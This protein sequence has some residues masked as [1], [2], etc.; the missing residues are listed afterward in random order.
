MR[1]LTSLPCNHI[2]RPD[3]WGTG[4]CIVTLLL[5]VILL[6]CLP[7]YA[8][9]PFDLGLGLGIVNATRDDS[10]D[11]GW[12][13][14]I[15]YEF[16]RVKNWNLGAQAQIL[17]GTAS[18]SDTTSANNLSFSSNALYLTARP[19]DWWFYF[20][21]GVVDGT[22]RSLTDEQHTTG[23][24]FGAGV[25]LEYGGIRFHLIDYQRFMI[26]AAAFDVFTISITVLDEGVH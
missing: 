14:Q 5:G 10:S 26:G 19:D 6:A 4:S 23:A 1:S 7:A 9:D 11:A 2:S 21:G 20:K 17:R 16:T 3:G 8:A 22:Y 24:A 25:A 12:D 13:L 18:L 15:G